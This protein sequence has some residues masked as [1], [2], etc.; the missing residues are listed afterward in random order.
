MITRKIFHRIHKG[1]QK[2]TDVVTL[3]E[4]ELARIHSKLNNIEKILETY[5]KPSCDELH[6][7]IQFIHRTYDIVKSPL[8][9]ISNKIK[10]FAP[11]TKEIDYESYKPLPSK[12]D[13]CD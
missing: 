7:H 10:A 11:K 13:E 9:Y 8:F 3:N 1:M 12:E 4:E 2:N 6:E 5:V